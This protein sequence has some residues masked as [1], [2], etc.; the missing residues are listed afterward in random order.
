MLQHS[1]SYRLVM[2]I[3]KAILTAGSVILTAVCVFSDPTDEYFYMQSNAFDAMKYALPN[4][5]LPDGVGYCEYCNKH[6]L[7]ASKHCRRCDRCIRGFD[8]HCRFIN[9]CV[10]VR[11]YRRFLMLV[12]I[13]MLDMIVHSFIIVNDV[14][15][16][17]RQSN[18]R[19]VIIRWLLDV[20][21]LVIVLASFILLAKLLVFHAYLAIIGLTTYEHIV[22]QRSRVQ[23]AKRRKEHVIDNRKA[24]EDAVN[25]RSRDEL[26]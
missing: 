5:R 8:H 4:N 18:E 1:S 9:Q 17:F 26:L 10:G 3:L 7:H 20:I 11:N 13:L 6:V 21:I 24:N 25:D 16:L 14:D 23:H 15:D 22:K 19:W 12:T 2:I